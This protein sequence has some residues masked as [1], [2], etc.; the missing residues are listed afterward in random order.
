MSRSFSTTMR[1]L[2]D[3]AWKSTKANPDYDTMITRSI[4]T[5]PKLSKWAEKVEVAGDE[6]GSNADPDLR[7]S[8]QIFNKEGVRITSGHW[9]KD[10]RVV[11][12]KNTF[13]K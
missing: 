9:Y 1:A 10:G 6:H 12:S 11:Y 8:G 2:L 7:V 13:N 3:I 5:H 4:E